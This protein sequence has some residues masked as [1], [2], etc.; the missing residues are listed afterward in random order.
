MPDKAGS[1][2]VGASLYLGIAFGFAWLFWLASWMMATGRLASP[3]LPSL[4]I[5]LVIGSFSPFVGAAVCTFV[6]GGFRRTL[7]YFGGAFRLK[8]G[9]FVFL[10]SFFL[11]P[12][13]CIVAAQI[14]AWQTHTP[15]VFQMTWA[16]FPQAYLFLFFLGGAVGEEFGWSYLS[17]KL[18]ERLP[19]GWATLL[20]GV[21]WSCWHI[22][23]FFIVYPG[24]SQH[25]TPFYIF[26][27]STTSL[28]FLLSWTYHRSGRNIL[29]N[30]I[31]HNASNLGISIVTIAPA[32][33]ETHH[34][35][36]WYV[37]ILTV[38]CAAGFWLIAPITK[39]PLQIAK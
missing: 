10:V 11:S 19:I 25:F 20:L 5:M 30:I 38:I 16:E 6:E 15:L 37:A 9:W 1:T 12:L 18:D 33:A 14:Y 39:L 32:M 31:F 21:I 8:M 26:L 13:I 17:D 34:D 27:I 3:Y 36:L 24:L 22:P 7:A 35:R 2:K 28:R 29:S 23:L 4:F